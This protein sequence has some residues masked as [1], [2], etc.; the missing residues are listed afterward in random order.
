MNA[1][2]LE[3]QLPDREARVFT[4]LLAVGRPI[5][6]Q[7]YTPDS[8]IISTAI[9]QDVLRRSG[10]ALEPMTVQLLACNTAMTA[11]LKEQEYQFPDD[12]TMTGWQAAGARKVQLGSGREE[13][14][15]DVIWPYH[16]VGILRCDKQRGLLDLSLDQL[17][18]YGMELGPLLVPCPGNFVKGRQYSFV[19]AD[20]FLS[21]LPRPEV[22]SY[23]EAPEWMPN[24]L[25]KHVT[26][27]IVAGM[28]KYL[29]EQKAA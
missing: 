27:L 14:R 9:A 18:P 11:M 12:A 4:A 29:K 5:L 2:T 3:I 22:T 15:G 1:T 17:N 25:R 21:Y 28:R 7:F 10:I 16:L 26:E 13:R 24:P 6:L 19:W 23:R 8:C 20:H